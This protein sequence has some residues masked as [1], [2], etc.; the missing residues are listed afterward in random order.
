MEKD[1]PPIL[2]DE[3]FAAL[4]K[5]RERFDRPEHDRWDNAGIRPPQKPTDGLPESTLEQQFAHIAQKLTAVWPS[6]A[7][8][9]LIRNLVV[10]DRESRQGFPQDVIEDLLMLSEIN[11]IR[12]RKIGLGPA[13][14]AVSPAKPRKP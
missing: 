4:L 9:L 7:C 12:L 13:S 1:F 3:E 6:E 14:A 11:E 10:N 8:A 5:Q 2:S